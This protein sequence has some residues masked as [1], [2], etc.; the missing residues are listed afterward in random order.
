[1]VVPGKKEVIFFLAHDVGRLKGVSMTRGGYVAR[2]L[3]KD[4]E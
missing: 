3:D 1:M 2:T 4:N